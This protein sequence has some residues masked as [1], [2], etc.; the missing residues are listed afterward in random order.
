[1]THEIKLEIVCYV[2]SVQKLRPRFKSNF[3]EK[4]KR[5]NFA[6]F[7]SRPMSGYL[8]EILEKLDELL[9]FK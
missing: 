6:K 5:Q 3:K 2:S 4:N 7:K 1:M 8:V 9:N